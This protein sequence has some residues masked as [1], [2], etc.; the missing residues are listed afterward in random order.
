MIQHNADTVSSY[1][2]NE[3]MRL[4]TEATV[5]NSIIRAHVELFTSYKMLGIGV[6]GDE[7]VDGTGGGGNHYSY[8]FII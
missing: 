1:N 5:L 8:Q 7:S 2:Y 3:R 4:I 6:R